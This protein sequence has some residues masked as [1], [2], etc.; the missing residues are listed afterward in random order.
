MWLIFFLNWQNFPQSCVYSLIQSLLTLLADFLSSIS[1]LN[2]CWRCAGDA[3]AN[4]GEDIQLTTTITHVE[5][6][7]EIYKMTGKEAQE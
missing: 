1:H 7:T 4:S 3:G 5:G 6:P 2:Q